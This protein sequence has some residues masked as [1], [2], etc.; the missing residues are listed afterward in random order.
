[1]FKM[2]FNL[3][4]TYLYPMSKASDTDGTFLQKIFVQLNLPPLIVIL[5][6]IVKNL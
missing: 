4:Q 3:L 1:M 2:L 6:A 5:L